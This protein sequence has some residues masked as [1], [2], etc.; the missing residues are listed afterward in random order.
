MRT[1]LVVEA[2]M[3]GLTAMVSPC[4]LPLHAAVLLSSSLYTC[5]WCTDGNKQ[6]HAS[7]SQVTSPSSTAGNASQAQV[8]A[9][10]Q[11]AQDAAKE[12]ALYVPELKLPSTDSKRRVV[13]ILGDGNFSFSLSLADALWGRCISKP[14]ADAFFSTNTFDISDDLYILATSF[15]QREELLD[16]YPE[17]AGILER[18]QR[19]SHVQVLHGINA[20]QIQDQLPGVQFDAIVWNHPHLGVEDF[21][22]HKFLMAHFFH[23]AEQCLAPNGFVSVSL[24]QGQ[25]ERWDITPQALKSGL[26]VS[27]HAAF[28]PCAWYGYQTKRNRTGQSFQNQHTQRHT[29]SSMSSQ[30][31]QY[32]RRTSTT[33]TAAEGAQHQQHQQQQQ[34]SSTASAPRTPQSDSATVA[35]AP[36]YEDKKSVPKPPPAPAAHVCQ[37]CGKGFALRRG[38]KTHTRQVH[39]LKKYGQWTPN[40]KKQLT[41]DECGKRFH[42]DEALWQHRVSKHS[43]APAPDPQRPLSTADELTAPDV[44]YIPC[45]VCGQAIPDYWHIEQHLEMLK[46]LVGIKAVCKLCSK[47]FTEHRALGQHLNFCRV[48]IPPEL[49]VRRRRRQRQPQHRQDSTH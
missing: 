14:A 38:L 43:A 32:R 7:S 31:L 16:K 36:A 45:P 21:R 17:T 25:A 28:D 22:L 8:Q 20:W 11:H 6:A 10:E 48:E 39:E 18:L 3:L 41:C 24:V 33:A 2:A 40:M 29:K 27:K 46:P 30:L 9:Q 12:G 19:F 4:L 47:V 1:T 44:H 15:D 23:S 34:Q 42:D 37:E 13:L 5:S 26:H 35:P 49:M